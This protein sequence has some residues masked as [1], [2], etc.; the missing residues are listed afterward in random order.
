MEAPNYNSFKTERWEVLD[1]KQNIERNFWHLYADRP[2]PGGG[3]YRMS[4]PRLPEK[5][6]VKQMQYEETMVEHG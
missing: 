4:A 6:R 1:S 2:A 5:R 3:V